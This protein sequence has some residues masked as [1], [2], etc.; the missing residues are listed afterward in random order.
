M[1]RWRARV[2]V[3]GHLAAGGP[4]GRSVPSLASAVPAWA[5]LSWCRTWPIPDMAYPAGHGL[6]CR[7]WPILR[8]TWPILRR[9]WPILRR[10]WPIL[11][12]AGHGLCRTPDMA[13]GGR[14][15]H[16]G[17]GNRAILPPMAEFTDL[18]DYFS[19]ARYARK[20]RRHFFGGAHNRLLLAVQNTA[21]RRAMKIKTGTELWRA[22]L[23]CVETEF[24]VVVRSAAGTQ[25]AD[26][27]DRKPYAPSRMKPLANRAKEGRANPKG[28]PC[29]YLSD[30]RD[31]AM[32][33][34]RSWEGSF[35]SCGQFFT[36]KPLKV[37]DCSFD[38]QALLFD[39]SA[40]PTP[41]DVERYVW[42]TINNAFSEPVTNADDTPDYAPTQILSEL[43]KETGFDGVRY[44]SRVGNGHSIAL[45]DLKAVEVK[46][47]LLFQTD[48]LK[49]T[50]KEARS[51]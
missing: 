41:E 8:R 27:M 42:G 43:F 14:R 3:G 4:W 40:E 51:D 18:T 45:F 19:F 6:S 32:S 2:A 47:V 33:E 37:V 1:W 23:G 24:S 7:T 30:D 16:F 39:F 26:N 29:I 46:E 44:S 50:F 17:K 9:T 21:E 34:M 38:E 13:Y 35:L 28:I 48:K 11:S 22:Q 20:K 49:V 31:T 5:S 15:S 25:E 12:G 36:T 10:T